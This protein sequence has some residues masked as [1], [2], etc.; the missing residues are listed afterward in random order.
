M[1]V[2][3]SSLRYRLIAAVVSLAIFGVVYFAVIKPNHDTANNA[4]TQSEKQLQQ[5]LNNVNKQSGVT[6][7]SSAV[8][9]SA[10]LA[11]AG[12]DTAKIQACSAASH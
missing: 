7:P 9:L 11:A 6:V 5:V 3:V 8:N 4:V 12:T 1:Y 2:I 10:C